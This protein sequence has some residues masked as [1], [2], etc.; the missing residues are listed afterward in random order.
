MN[1]DVIQLVVQVDDLIPR[2][3]RMNVFESIY[4]VFIALGTLVGIIVIG[5]MTY[6]AYRYRSTGDHAADGDD[7]RPYLGELPTG[8]GK[9]RK[10][11]LSF[12]LSAVV[13]ISLIVWTYGTLLYVESPVSAQEADEELEIQVVGQQFAWEFIYPNGESS[14]EL[15]VPADQ[16]V[17][18]VVTSDDVF[19]N[20]GIPA[21]RAKT[22]AIPGQTTETWFI[23]EQPGEYQAHCYELCGAGHSGMNAKVVVMEPSAYEE[24]YA[25]M[26]E[27]ASGN[28]SGDASGENATATPTA[29]NGTNASGTAST[30]ASENTS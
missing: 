21:L 27:N 25:S 3:T 10:L 16:R 28:G 9:G 14:F 5:Y 26:G 7:D 6:S 4:W 2:G 13:V 17:R 23:A 12:A 1:G 8:G 30:N 24:W 29:G 22:D 11:F 19:H 20:F 18:L 15:H